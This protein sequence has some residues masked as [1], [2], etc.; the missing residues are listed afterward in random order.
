[1][2]GLLRMDHWPRTWG[3]PAAVALAAIL[4]VVW[5]WLPSTVSA[6]GPVDM[7]T[8]TGPGLNSAVEITEP[9]SLAPFDP[10]TR[11][12]IDWGRGIIDEPPTSLQTYEVTFYLD[13]DG[14]RN[15]IYVIEYSP[16]PQGG[17]GY[18]Y[19]PPAGIN[20]STITTGDS[21]LWDPNFKW[22][23]A[24]A[25]WGVLM[26]RALRGVS[27]KGEPYNG[28]IDKIT[29]TGPGLRQPIEVADP[30]SLARFVLGNAGLIDWQWPFNTRLST[31]ITVD[32][33]TDPPQAG[34]TYKVLFHIEDGDGA[35]RVDTL[36]YYPDPSGGGYILRDE[37]AL[38]PGIAGTWVKATDDLDTSMRQVLRENGVS[39]LMAALPT[40]GEGA[41]VATV[42]DSE[43]V[44][45]VPASS[46]V[47]DPDDSIGWLIALGVLGLLVGASSLVWFGRVRS[48]SGAIGLGHDH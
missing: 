7:I 48:T 35:S 38:V 1:M 44:G 23:H 40:G 12:F 37:V 26:E 14:S 32:F 47:I 11:G 4:L 24:T 45:T 29:L 39:P 3:R 42:A 31:S 16:D 5:L 22:Q 2:R 8:V 10:W 30:M 46:H 18:I 43:D 15:R 21:D 25:A 36:R 9:D 41:A 20:V 27:D 19:I 34:Q 28:R 17:L 6:K 33:L 13:N